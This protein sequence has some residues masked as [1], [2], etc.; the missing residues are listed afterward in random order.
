VTDRGSARRFAVRL[1]ACCLVGSLLAAAGPRQTRDRPPPAH[2]GGFDEPTCVS[3][4][5][6]GDLND[7]PGNLLLHGLPERY[8]AG[9]SYMVTVMLT[10]P[11]L[12]A[13][14]FQLAARFASDGRQAGSLAAAPAD[15]GHVEITTEAGIQ[16]AHHGPAGTTPPEEGSMSWT[17]IWTAPAGPA[18]GLNEEDS[19]SAGTEVAV[20]V[21]A[22]AADGDDSPLGDRI[23]TSVQLLRFQRPSTSGRSTSSR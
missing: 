11:D 23:Y 8:V 4:H 14:G 13:A 18:A 19:D 12:A 5:F 3:C 2:T 6:D 16:Y 1:A 20:H 21:I 10:D 9:E 15:S 17:V 7:G 22:N